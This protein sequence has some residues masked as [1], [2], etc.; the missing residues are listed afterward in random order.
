MR[1]FALAL[2]GLAMCSLLGFGCAEATESRPPTGGAGG[3]GGDGSGG[4]AQVGSGNTSTG[5][6]TTGQAK[7]VINEIFATGDE[8]IELVNV[9][10]A[11]LDLEGYGVADQLDDGTPKLMDAVR[12]EAGTKLS[13]GEYLLIVTNVKSPSSGVQTDCLAK[14]GPPTCYQAVFGISASNGDKIF[15]LSP[16]D[17]IL[18]EAPYPINAVAD[19]QSYGRLPNGIGMFAACAPTP[20]EANTGP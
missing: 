6:G 12:F 2:A 1:R 9:G 15:F 11:V 13:P 5:T 17:D 4:S 18:E 7:V 20:G 19:G 16:K 3:S 10:D 14:G 8:W